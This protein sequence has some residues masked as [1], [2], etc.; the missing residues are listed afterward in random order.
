MA[1][2]FFAGSDASGMDFR[3]MLKKKKYAKNQLDDQ[4]PEWGEL[5]NVEVEQPPVLKKTEKVRQQIEKGIRGWVL[6]KSFFSGKLTRIHFF[7]SFPILPQ[8]SDS[9]TAFVFFTLI[10]YSNR[11]LHSLSSSVCCL[12]TVPCR[13]T[14]WVCEKIAQKCGPTHFCVR[15]E[16]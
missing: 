4:G 2:S 13:V 3:A 9:S 16:T 12:S 6:K 8:L 7:H 15:V 1:F 14:G 5:K 11:P 10:L